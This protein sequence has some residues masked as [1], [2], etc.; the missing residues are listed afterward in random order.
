MNGQNIKGRPQGYMKK[1]MKTGP[2]DAYHHCLTLHVEEGQ[3]EWSAFTKLLL[4]VYID[5]FIWCQD[6]SV[7]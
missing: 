1:M 7:S 2:S 5:K 6:I 3:K 4:R